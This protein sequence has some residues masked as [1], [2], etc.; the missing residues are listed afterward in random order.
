MPKFAAMLLLL[1]C[2]CASS[3]SDLIAERTLPCGPG[4]DIDI[5]AYMGTAQGARE[6][7]GRIDVLFTVN[8][9]N[10]SGNDIDVKRITIEPVT[11][12]GMT[13][14]RGYREFDVTVAEGEEHSFEIPMRARVPEF[15]SQGDRHRTSVRED[16]V[17]AMA[18]KVTLGN[19]D[20]YLC[21]Y[22]LGRR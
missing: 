3:D 1:I 17:S 11:T 16:G 15:G 13:M 2:G 6:L 4:Q 22:T 21:R 12:G 14:E 10:S 5:M 18:I 20:T 9:F 7:G 19:G 8:V